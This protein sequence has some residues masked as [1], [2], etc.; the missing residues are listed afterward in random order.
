MFDALH[1]FPLKSRPLRLGTFGDTQLLDFLPLPV[2][3]MAQQ[4]QLIADKALALALAAIE[5]SDYQPGVQAIARTFK[6]R[7]RQD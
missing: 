1:D 4:H 5:Q 2:N 3:A 7:I 6:Q